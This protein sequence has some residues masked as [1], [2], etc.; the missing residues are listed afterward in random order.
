L[1]RWENA[2]SLRIVPGREEFPRLG[3]SG[4]N[5]MFELSYKILERRERQAHENFAVCRSQSFFSHLLRKSKTQ[6]IVFVTP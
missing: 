1:R 3:A 2:I 5:V 6:S 4:T